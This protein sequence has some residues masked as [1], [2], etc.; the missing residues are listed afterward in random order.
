MFSLEVCSGGVQCQM[1]AVGAEADDRADGDIGKTGLVT[2]RL[3]RGHVRQMHFDERQGGG[4]QRIPQRDTGVGVGRGVEDDAIYALVTRGVNAVDQSAFAVGLKA[5]ERV[6]LCTGLLAQA[7][8]DVRQRL[9]A[10]QLGLTGAEQVQV[11][12]VEQEEAGHAI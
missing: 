12:T 2:E 9:C 7:V 8:F 4:Q 3:A 5:G 10:V 6:T 1:I 11:G